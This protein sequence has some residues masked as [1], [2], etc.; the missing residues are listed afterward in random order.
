[1]KVSDRRNL[2]PTKEARIA[3]WIWGS[4]YSKQNGGCMDFWDSLGSAR[5]Q[6]VKDI[7]LEAQEKK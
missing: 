5:R 1:M 2:N 6:L 3:M 7:I 4:E